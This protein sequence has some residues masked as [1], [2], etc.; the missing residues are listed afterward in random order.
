MP[1]WLNG[2]TDGRQRKRGHEGVSIIGD[3]G[4]EKITKEEA[5]A[6]GEQFYFTGKECRYGHISKR[7]ASSGNCVECCKKIF[8]SG[9][10]DGKK[11]DPNAEQKNAVALPELTDIVLGDTSRVIWTLTGVNAGDLSKQEQ[12]DHIKKLG[13]ISGAVQW[14]LGDHWNKFQGADTER[15]SVF[16]SAGY[17]WKTIYQYGLVCKRFPPDLRNPDVSYS[18]HRLIWDS[19][20][21]PDDDTTK[22]ALDHVAFNRMTVRQ[23]QAWLRQGEQPVTRVTPSP[24]PAAELRSLSRLIEKMDIY[25]PELS[26]KISE[27]RALISCG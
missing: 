25:P 3:R 12:V 19:E 14:A 27:L 18:I 16:E 4:M 6:A 8:D 5:I 11:F 10:Q 13:L 24:S 21:F 9:R 7:Y 23:V 15:R 20:L 22:N 2:W 1:T 26:D 17:K